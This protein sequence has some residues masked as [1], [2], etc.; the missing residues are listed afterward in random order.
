MS[1]FPFCLAR[2]Q[3]TN[4]SVTNA[5]EQTIGWLTYKMIELCVFSFRVCYFTSESVSNK[6]RL[7]SMINHSFGSGGMTSALDTT[8]I[9][10]FVQYLQRSHEEPLPV[11]KAILVTG[12][13]PDGTW[14]L[15]AT[16]FISP[17]GI[18]LSNQEMVFLDKNI[19]SESDKI[20]SAD[21]C[22]HITLPLS[23]EPLG[24]LINLMEIIEKHNFFSS[25]LVIAGVC[26]AFH[27]EVVLDLYGGCPITIALGEAETGKST[28]IRA[29]LALF[30]GDE[31]C[32]YVKGTNAAFLERSCRSS[33]PFAIEEASKGKSKTRANQLDLT[34]L[35]IDLY[36]G[37][38]STNM[39]TGSIKPKSIPVVA[40]NF[41]IDDVDRYV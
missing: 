41:D 25:L 38:R 30:G 23:L 22:P 32:R 27:Y 15:N 28:A 8:Q 17:A 10:E 37:V 34:E 21:I 5:C 12:R 26:L 3:T 1:K 6:A 31:V 29:G 14:V 19:I 13:Q 39:R 2:H 33:L 18:F 4:P 9:V 40:S 24:S 11:K 7:M 36:N 35:I 20:V 16:T